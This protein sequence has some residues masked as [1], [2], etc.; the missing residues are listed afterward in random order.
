MKNNL[1]T[2]ILYPCATCNLKCR[3]CGIDKNL[4]L[5]Q[6]DDAL[7][8]SFKLQDYYENCFKKYF[9][10]RGQ[11]IKI[12]TWGGEPFLHMDRIYNLLHWIIN[13][14]P[15]F[16]SM[17]S[18]TN[19]SYDSWIE[20]FLNLMNQLGQYPYRDFKYELQLSVDG[21]KEINDKN[22]GNGTTEK[23]L[24]NYNKLLQELKNGKLPNNIEL[25]ISLKATLD[26]D[27]LYELNSKEKIIKYYQ[28]FEENFYFPFIEANLSDN[29]KFFNALPNTAV[30]SPTTKQDGEVFAN[31]CK[32]SR[33]IEQEN[34]TY[35]YFQSYN[36]ITMFDNDITQQALTYKYNNHTCGTGINTIGFLPN[37]M[38]STCHEGFT[39]FIQEY[40]K[41]A[42]NS[43]RLKTSTINFDKFITEQK[44]P[45]CV[46]EVGF[47]EH[48]RKMNMYA[49]ENSTARLAN[50]TVEIISLAMSGEIDKKFLSPE[51]AL[52]GAIFIQS[53]TS[54]CIKD[55]YNETGSFTTIPTGILKL[56]LNGA[57]D[58]IQ[59]DGELKPERN[60]CNGCRAC[61]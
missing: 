21:P 25:S 56:L 11:L 28:W 36:N 51:N 10:N 5:K 59:H 12:E 15:Y 60:I 16:D 6:I 52:K 39:H 38:I 17:F 7:D 18:S 45:F 1:N 49:T 24:A 41:Y 14:Y 40:N 23:C 22:R 44:L 42:S 31:I 20:Q 33:E 27:N 54:Y 9:P 35:H 48:Q 19:F 53:H 8:Q 2:A 34:K 47:K 46:D 55:N 37:H 26:M 32:L 50:I 43:D 3:Y 57:M 58:Y 4:I 61:E 13:Y 29:I 30:P